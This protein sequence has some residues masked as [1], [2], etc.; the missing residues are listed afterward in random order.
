[1]RIQGDSGGIDS[2]FNGVV[3]DDFAIVRLCHSVPVTIEPE[4]NDFYLVQHKLSGGGRVQNGAAR[5]EMTSGIITVS[6]PGKATLVE[7]DPSSLSIV[8]KLPR[9]KL[10][11]HLQDLLQRTIRQPV[12]F[13]MRMEAHS[14]I[15]MSWAQAV[16]HVCDQY[17][18]LNQ[19]SGMGNR[20][21]NTFAEYMIGLLLHMQPHNYTD[22]LLHEEPGVSPRH[23]RSAVDFIH[24]HL[25]EHIGMLMLAK[26]SG[27]SARTLQ[28]NFRRYLGISPMEYVREQRIQYVHR[29]LLYVNTDIRVTDIF[30]KYGIYNFGRFAC[31]YR[32]R[33]G[34]L[35]SET[36]RKRRLF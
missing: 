15:A 4:T 33:Y 13:S 34:C 23:V 28:A 18:S 26:H 30:T 19:N 10:E 5:V 29:E 17:E 12:A 21:G 24:G 20:C 31:A 6:S 3:C 11:S 2:L 16:Q 35:P 1:M 14:S 8:V 7:L 32:K 36:L 22:S 27:V 25:A 9:Q